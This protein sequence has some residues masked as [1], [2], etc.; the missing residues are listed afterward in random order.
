M[1]ERDDGM[2]I[3]RKTRDGGLRIEEAAGK[4]SR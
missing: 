1:G 3:W 4:V 2:G